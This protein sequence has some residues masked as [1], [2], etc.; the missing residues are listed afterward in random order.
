MLTQWQVFR[1]AL[2]L[3]GAFGM[4][5]CKSTSL[6]VDVE[7]ILTWNIGFHFPVIKCTFFSVIWKGNVPVDEMI[8]HT[9]YL[10]CGTME[11]G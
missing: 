1:H 7:F 8:F 3:H 9:N 6:L 5:L 10:L 11:M 4:W 2:L